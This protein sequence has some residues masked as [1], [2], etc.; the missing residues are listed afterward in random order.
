MTH[1]RQTT[2]KATLFALGLC[3]LFQQ[4]FITTAAQAETAVAPEKNPP[5]DIPDSQVFIAYVGSSYALK[6]PEGWARTVTGP[7]VIFASKLD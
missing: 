4:P 3:A 2:T 1:F 7:N 6:V 5:G